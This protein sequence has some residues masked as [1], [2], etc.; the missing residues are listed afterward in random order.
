MEQNPLFCGQSKSAAK[1]RA[2][3]Y[4]KCRKCGNWSHE[5][6]E[7]SKN[8]TYSQNEYVSLIQQGA[9]RFRAEHS[10]R[11]GSN[12]YYAVKKEINM[13][14]DEH[15]M[16]VKLLSEIAAEQVALRRGNFPNRLSNN[17]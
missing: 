1:R 10:I 4:E 15:N 7:C 3:R 9:I 2:K 5:G 6:E 12:V 11:K 14:K 13:M 16:D 8:Q 17:P